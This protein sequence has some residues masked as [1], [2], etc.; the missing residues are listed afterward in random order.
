[1]LSTFEPLTSVVVGIIVYHETLTMRTAAGI[2][3]ILL[4]V[5]LL[6][7][8]KEAPEPCGTKE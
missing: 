5:Y 3:C 1:M 4:A 2:V 6:A 7:A 8:A